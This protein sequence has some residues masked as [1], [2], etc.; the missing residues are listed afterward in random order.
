MSQQEWLDIFGDNLASILEEEQISQ[1]ELSRLTGLSESTISRY[2]NK[3]Q[4]PTVR[5]IINI[6]YA[7]DWSFEDMLNYGD[8]VEDV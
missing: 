2:I 8:I 3:L 6:S 5:A 7:L 4:M 1:K